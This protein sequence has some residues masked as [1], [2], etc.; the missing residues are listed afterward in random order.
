MKKFF[1]LIPALVSFQFSHAQW[2]PDV[3]LTN[4]PFTSNTSIKQAISSS[5]DSI[6]VVW[7]DDR[8]GNK[9][10]YY[11]RSFDGGLTWEEDTRLTN[12]ATNSATASIVVSGPVIHVL[13][14]EDIE[15]NTE[16]FYKRS[17]DGGNTWGEDVRLTN[18]P[19]ITSG[20]CM[21]VS[22]SL[23]HLIYYDNCDYS[24]EVFYRSSIDAGLTWEP[25]TRLTFDPALSGNTSVCSNDPFVHVVWDDQRDGNREIYYKQSINNGQTW[26]MDTRLT[27]DY[28]ASWV[29]CV[30]VSGSD[31][32]V[33]WADCRDGNSE[34]YFKHSTDGGMT[35]GDDAR[36]TNNTADSKFP[37]LS[38]DGGS[39][40]LVWMEYCDGNPEIY[41]KA[42]GDRGFT[43]LP[44]ER[45]T[46]DLAESRYPTVCSSE[47]TVNV[48]WTDTRDENA[49]IYYKRDPAGNPVGTDE[50]FAGTN[51]G[52]L[53]IYPNPASDFIHVTI[54][55]NSKLPATLY[56]RNVW[57][58]EVLKVQM[59]LL[60]S[61]VDISG[62]QS[63]AYHA[64]LQKQDGS[65][66]SGIL[67]ISRK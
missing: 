63:G 19:L 57:G 2:E 13:W 42:S 21:S 10:I 44:E 51:A 43:W 23:V 9:E 50:H 54:N 25:E 45:L 5:G 62:I 64:C 3:R 37:N 67:I 38:A 56:I 18:T 26:G 17:G 11:K 29:P 1:L 65:Q 41:F 22:G 6:Q 35:W 52:Q 20:N 33:A 36:L 34:I 16:V 59:G 53:S 27:E 15:G 39:I 61:V 46:D 40:F 66:L 48:A 14:N 58:Q 47:S 28:A 8:D 30:A 4:D 60:G 31:V 32:Y 24:W 7:D 55:E 12:T 49:E